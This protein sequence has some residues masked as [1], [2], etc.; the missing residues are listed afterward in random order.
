[1]TIFPDF[2]TGAN[3]MQ[4]LSEIKLVL[5]DPNHTPCMV[6]GNKKAKILSSVVAVY[7]EQ[8]LSEF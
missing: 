2:G 6:K 3:N 8:K 4:Q 1:M 7:N 5:W